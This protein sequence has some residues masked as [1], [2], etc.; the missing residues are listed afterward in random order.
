MGSYVG[1]D[2]EYGG[3]L[4]HLEH[5][6]VIEK[7]LGRKLSKIE[8]VHHKNHNKLDNRL[9]N[10]ELTK[11]GVHQTK[12]ARIF[13]DENSKEC[14]D[15]HRI[16]P[17]NMFGKTGSVGKLSDRNRSECRDCHQKRYA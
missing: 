3:K 14:I 5:R 12:H 8:H 2:S 1:Y 17:R 10:L 16:L 11:N 7:Y 4:Y 13:R 6:Y 15:C 9:L